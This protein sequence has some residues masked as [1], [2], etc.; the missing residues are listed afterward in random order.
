MKP[1]VLFDID[2]VI[3]DWKKTAI[4]LAGQDAETAFHH[5]VSGNT[6]TGKA[7]GM[8][9]RAL[10]KLV[11]EHPSW[12]VDLPK[13]AWADELIQHVEDANVEWFFCTAQSDD[14]ERSATQK[15]QWAKK[16]GW[17]P[18]KK[19]CITHQKWLLAS[20]NKMLI[21]DKDSN[22]E[23]FRK[24]GGHGLLMP[25]PWNKAAEFVGDRMQYVRNGIE[26][27]LLRVRNA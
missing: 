24:A 19:L 4:E 11:C 8:S 7:I 27:F 14:D 17:I 20:F 10:W 1:I 22:I 9:D 5:W 2:D 16:H 6:S 12:W 23:E 26:T 13:T 3:V 21:D 18:K 15:V 25:Q